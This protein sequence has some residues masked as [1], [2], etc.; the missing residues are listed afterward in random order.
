L[1]S[2]VTDSVRFFH[3]FDPVPSS[4]FYGNVW[5]HQTNEAVMLFDYPTSDCKRGPPSCYTGVKVTGQ[6]VKTLARGSTGWKTNTAFKNSMVKTENNIQKLLC[7]EYDVIPSAKVFRSSDAYTYY[8][9]MNMFNPMPCA[10]VVLSALYKTLLYNK[11]YVAVGKEPWVPKE[12]FFDCTMTYIGTLK[13]YAE[14]FLAS[15]LEDFRGGKDW[16]NNA[17]EHVVYTLAWGL[18]F[19]HMTYPFYPMCGEYGEI[20]GIKPGIDKNPIN[21][22]MDTIKESLPGFSPGPVGSGYGF[23]PYDWGKGS[24]GVS[25]PTDAL[26]K[27]W[28]AQF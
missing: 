27:F 4:L 8:S 19:V 6:D 16:E 7:D 21:T 14:A 10:E 3:K 15:D 12:T 2:I 18:M 28:E 13:A 23:G 5:A 11:I 24:E 20:D 1:N 26:E 9:Y 17:L 22:F 25:D